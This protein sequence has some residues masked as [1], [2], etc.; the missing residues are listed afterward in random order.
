MVVKFYMD[1]HVP[2]PIVKGTRGRQLDAL[3][4]QEDHHDKADDAELLARAS[5]LGRVLVSA[6]RDFFTIVATFQSLNRTCA[7]V[8]SISNRQSYRETID[9]LEMIAKCT[10]PEEWANLIT[11]LPL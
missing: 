5:Q 4:A 9:D 6:D 8:I 11:R 7:G 1:E 10:E 2:G 3:T